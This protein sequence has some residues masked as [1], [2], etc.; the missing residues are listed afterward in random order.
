MQEL[1]T[2]FQELGYMAHGM[3]LMWQPWLIA[4]F[5]GSDM[6]IFLAY[7]LIPFAL[8]R[9][10]R[11]RPDIEHRGVAY[12]FVAFILLCGLT[13]LVAIFTLWVPVYVVQG[14]VKLATALVSVTTAAVL[15]PLIPRII[16]LPSPVELRL[17]NADLRD[18]IA[19]HENTLIQ[20]RRARD[21]LE[22]KVAGRTLE[23]ERANEELSIVLWEAGNR[24]RNLKRLTEELTRQTAEHSKTLAE[25]METFQ[26]RIADLVEASDALIQT[27]ARLPST[28]RDLAEMQLAPYIAAYP[29]RIRLL[30]EDQPLPA[31]A[32]RQIGLALNELATNAV[33]HGALRDVDGSVELSWA[34]YRGWPA[35][36]DRFQ[37]FWHERLARARVNAMEV[38]GDSLGG[39]VGFGSRVL[40]ITVPQRL[41]GR[42]EVDF[43]TEG[44]RY[45]LDLPAQA[46]EAGSDLPDTAAG[47]R[48]GHAPDAGVGDA[49]NCDFAGPPVVPAR[50]MA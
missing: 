19:A 9:V 16:A 41:G 27:D 14:Y 31:K 44:L 42:A 48:S 28:M 36:D 4:M 46:L 3:C 50:R 13:H 8:L 26:G 45:A 15:F 7:A 33:K 29:G 1:I 12:L 24:G 6:L 38:A 5:A 30:G 35:A 20:L 49:R 32:A 25:F 34:H 21:R 39:P 18:E 40:N 37:V 11:A 23:L 47:A 22:D 17:V 2:F 10:L 43:S